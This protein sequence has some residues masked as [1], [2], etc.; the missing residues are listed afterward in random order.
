MT[1]PVSMNLASRVPLL[2]AALVVLVDVWILVVVVV[3]AST[4]VVV[5][6]D[7]WTL[8]VDGVEVAGPE[9]HA[10]SPAPLSQTVAISAARRAARRST[11]ECSTTTLLGFVSC[12]HLGEL[13]LHHSQCSRR[14]RWLFR[15]GAAEPTCNP[16]ASLADVKSGAPSAIPPDES[17]SRERTLHRNRLDGKAVQAGQVHHPMCR[18]QQSAA[19]HGSLRNHGKSKPGQWLRLRSAVLSPPRI[20]LRARK[21]RRFG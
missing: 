4:V 17:R 13:T 2:G 19:G 7:V 11:R 8:T 18:S 5:V 3:D 15:S 16:S 6:A 14:I 9:E 1:P 10:A 12:R 21:K 20:P